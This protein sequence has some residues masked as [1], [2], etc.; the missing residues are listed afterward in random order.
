MIVLVTG[1]APFGGERINSSWEAVQRLPRQIGGARI[2]RLQIPTVFYESLECIREKI[3]EVHPDLILSV[4]Q[5]SGRSALSLERVARNVMTCTIPD[6]AGNQP[7]NEPIFA[8]GPAELLSTLPVRQMVQD[9]R[10]AGIPAE[11]SD[12]AGTFVCNHVFYGTRYLCD[13]YYPGIASGFLHLP[14]LP[15]QVGDLAGTPSLPLPQMVQGLCTALESA[16]AWREK[17]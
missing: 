13:R 14:C 8:D 16:V 9:I 10:Q 11:L 7:V 5:A 4:G 2:V 1:F 3:D 17:D 15:E 6:N 12:T